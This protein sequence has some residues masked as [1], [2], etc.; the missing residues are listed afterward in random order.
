MVRPT[1]LVWGL[2]LLALVLPLAFPHA[3]EP[4]AAVSAPTPPAPETVVATVNGEPLHYGAIELLYRSLPQQ[5]QQL[6][7][8]VLYTQLLDL[9]IDRRLMGEWA[10]AEK[11]D[12]D[13]D[14]MRALGFAEEGV[15]ESRYIAKLLKDGL[16]EERLHL[17]YDAM[18]EAFV[19]EE[20]VHAR[21]ILFKTEDEAKTIIAELEKGADF[22]ALATEKSI[23]PS[24]KS[25]AGDLDWFTREKM[26]PEFAEAAFALKDGETTAEPVKSAFGWHVI[27]LEGRR[28]S[29]PPSFE[30]S[31]DQLRAQEAEA[32]ITGALD[33]LR[34]EATIERF[35]ADGKP[36]ESETP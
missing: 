36:L 31:L 10:R 28:K 24:A 5:Y 3:E 13:P 23:D 30:S 26:V 12:E 34:T 11:I 4:E 35:G 14:V 20:E 15:L 29:E 19:P 7:I 17:A 22:A 33:A 27:K 2:A 8:D 25:N 1:R 21:H 32:L 9:L 16:T 18:L 6:P